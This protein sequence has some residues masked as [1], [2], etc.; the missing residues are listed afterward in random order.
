[1]LELVELGERL[2][3]LAEEDAAADVQD[4]RDL[5]RA[6]RSRRELGH[7]REQGRREVVDH[8]VAEVLEAPGGLGPAGAG[9]AGDDREPRAGRSPPRRRGLVHGGAASGPAWGIVA[10]DRRPRGHADTRRSSI[11]AVAPVSR[12][13]TAR[14][15]SGPTPGV[16]AISATSARDSRRAT[17]TA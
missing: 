3:E 13:W 6:A 12:S 5:A 15:T 9:Q 1:M 14:A 11:A 10:T 16:A 2:R 7:L 17:R 8:E 4:D